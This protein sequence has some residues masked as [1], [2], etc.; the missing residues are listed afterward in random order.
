MYVSLEEAKQWCRVYVPD[1]DELLAN[2]IIP[3]AEGAVENFLGR[4]LS[5]RGEPP[6]H[7]EGTTSPPD[8]DLQLLP[9]VK[10]GILYY[11]GDFYE[12]REITALG[13]IVAV[14]K[15]AE[16]ILYPFRVGLGV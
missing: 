5:D 14:N 12:N 6:L 16:G 8:L 9:T 10:A 7:V 11:V 1:D 13:T 3:A 2:I 15:M 4:K